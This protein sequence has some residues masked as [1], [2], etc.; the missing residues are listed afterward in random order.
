MQARWR[1]LMEEDGELALAFAKRRLN[2]ADIAEL[3]MD[4]RYWPTWLPG[5]VFNSYVGREMATLIEAVRTHPDFLPWR[6]KEW[7]HTGSLLKPAKSAAPRTPRSPDRVIKDC[8]V[9]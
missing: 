5:D 4:L 1:A 7:K 6:E 2:L 8:T 3:G 9:E